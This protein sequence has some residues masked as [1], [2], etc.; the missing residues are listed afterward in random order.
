MSLGMPLSTSAPV[1]TPESFFVP[2]SP[3][4]ASIPESGEPA[5]FP[6]QPTM[7]AAKTQRLREFYALV[8]RAVGPHVPPARFTSLP[9]RSAAPPGRA[10]RG[11]AARRANRP[12]L[13]E[14]LDRSLRRRAA[15]TALLRGARL[16]AA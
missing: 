15:P 12:A 11:R 4:D 13:L 16:R 6:P 5:V 7:S 9:L 3:S 10:E 14:G 2:E 8:L 1:S